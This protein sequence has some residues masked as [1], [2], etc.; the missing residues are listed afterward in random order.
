MLE[1]RLA[2]PC[3]A[4]WESM[5]TV[6]G[7]RHCARCDRAVVDLGACAPSTSERVL[8]DAADRL[9]RG[10]RV[11][12]KAP[13]DAQ[14]RIVAPRRRR[15]F[16]NALAA[17]LALAATDGEAPAAEE[18]PPPPKNLPMA[19]GGICAIAQVTDQASSTTYRATLGDRNVS[20][21]RDGKALWTR[22]L[23]ERALVRDLRLVAGELVIIAADG[24]ERRL[25]AA[26][27]TPIDLVR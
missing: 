11:C 1:F 27:G 10:E 18:A 2:H 17:L 16:S 20:A 4:D 5:R 23:P 6:P 3:D 9:A 8:A 24:I 21:M 7:G 22:Q 25:R 12:L 13:Q 14:G 19:P 15:L 26:D